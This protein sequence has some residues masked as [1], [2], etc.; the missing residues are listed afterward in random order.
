M[1]ANVKEINNKNNDNKEKDIPP[2]KSFLVKSMHL[3]LISDQVKS[4]Q[5]VLISDHVR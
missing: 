2:K 1:I 3:V 5:L 4:I